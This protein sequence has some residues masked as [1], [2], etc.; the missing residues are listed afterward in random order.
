MTEKGNGPSKKV[1]AKKKPV[2]KPPAKSQKGEPKKITAP[3]YNVMWEEYCNSQS[4]TRCAKAA[5]VSVVTARKYIT[6]KASPKDGL[7]PIRKRYLKATAEAQQKQEQTLAEW[8]FTQATELK[9]VVAL[10]V[11]EFALLQKHT[12]QR[13]KRYEVQLKKKPESL[14]EIEISLDR[15]VNSMDKV[16]RLTE[17]LLGGNDLNVEIKST[18]KFAGWTKEEKLAWATKGILPEHER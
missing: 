16:I 11:A 5:N 8:Q 13:I 15:L 17:H 14:P 3:I 10:H 9:K 7:E 1:A 4:V 2:K 12:T 18:S 6:G